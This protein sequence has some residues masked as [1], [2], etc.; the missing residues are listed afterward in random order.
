M[1]Q[2]SQYKTPSTRSKTRV[3][4]PV[5]EAELTDQTSCLPLRYAN[6]LIPGIGLA[7][8][9]YDMLT[10]GEGKIKWGDGLVW[11]KS[12]QIDTD[13]DNPAIAVD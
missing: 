6:K 2:Q 9:F 1:I 13:P 4:V 7:L 5:V 11:H 12:K 3:F 8:A 10:C